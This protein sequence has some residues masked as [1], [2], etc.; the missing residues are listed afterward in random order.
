MYDGFKIDDSV[1]IEVL[2]KLVGNIPKLPTL[3]LLFI[4]ISLLGKEV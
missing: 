1:V 4:P 2:L 3:H